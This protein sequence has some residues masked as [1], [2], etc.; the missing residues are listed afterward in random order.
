MLTTPVTFSS[1]VLVSASPLQCAHQRWP[2]PTFP[3]P[4]HTVW[5]YGNT[6]DQT[7]SD[8]L[9]SQMTKSYV[10]VRRWLRAFKGVFRRLL[11]YQNYAYK[12]RR[13][14]VF[15]PSKSQAVCG[16]KKRVVLG[17]DFTW[18]WERK[19]AL[20]GVAFIRGSTV[21]VHWFLLNT[22]HLHLHWLMLL[23]GMYCQHRWNSLSS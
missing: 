1:S 21:P 19:L 10:W 23:L 11:L 4:L 7:S 17:Q 2:S 15:I 18:Q 16:L 3:V 12:Y 9:P 5:T 8:T 6:S 20:K 22:L 13:I 14:A